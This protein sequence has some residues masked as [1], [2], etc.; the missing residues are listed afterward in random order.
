MAECWNRPGPTLLRH[1]IDRAAARDPD[2]AFIVAADDG[3]TLTYGQLREL[4]GRIA[5]Y[6]RDQGI[7]ANDRVAL[8]SNNSIEHLAAY[9]GVLAY[10]ATICTVHVEMNRNQLDNI[11][12]LLK[13]RMVLCEDG[14]GLDDMLKAVSRRRACRSAHGTTGAA[15]AFSRRSTLRAGRCRTPMPAPDDGAVIL[16]T[17]GT[18]ARPKGVV[19]SFRELLSNAGPTADG[20]DLTAQ[21]RIYDFRSF[22]WCSAQTLSAVPP[23]CRGA[24]LILGRKFSRSRFFDHISAT[25][26]DHRDRQ[27]DHHR[28]PAQRRRACPRRNCRRSAS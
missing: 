9:F 12:P 3:R 25:R 19:L 23:L 20:F 11:L 15:T 17:S 24:T 28:P 13:P 6:L 7:G 18:S 16:F 5:T 14:L 8:L 1:W 2:K 10:G 21:D 22:N 27:S 4:T 26:R